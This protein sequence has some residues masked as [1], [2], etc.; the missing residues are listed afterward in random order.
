M[1]YIYFLTAVLVSIS[2]FSQQKFS[3]TGHIHDLPEATILTLFKSEGSRGTRVGTDTVRN[4]KK[5]R[6]LATRFG[7]SSIPHYALISPEGK[8]LS[9]WIGYEEGM[10]KQKIKEFV[11]IK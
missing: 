11:A 6:G 4:C 1:K 8:L 10:L 9:S 3:I 2:C 5:N 7:V